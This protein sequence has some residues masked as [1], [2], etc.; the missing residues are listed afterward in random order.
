MYTE[1]SIFIGY[2]CIIPVI[3]ICTNGLI[4]DILLYSHA[5][6]ISCILYLLI[7]QVNTTTTEKNELYG[8]RHLLFNLRL[9]PTTLWFNMGLWDKPDLTFPQACENLVHAV[10]KVMDI[11][12]VSTVLDV[13]FGCGD[14]CIVLAE[15]YTLKVTGITNE[16]SQWRIASDRISSTKLKDQITLIHGSADDLNQHISSTEIYDYIVSIDSAYHYNTRWDF[17]KNALTYLKP[18]GGTIGLYDLCIDSEFL[19]EVSSMQYSFL[20]LIC[21]ASHIPIR[22]LVT[23]E[24]YQKRLVDMGY[25]KIEMISL[26][27]AHVFGGL[28]ESFNDQYNTVMKYGIGVSLSNKIFLKGSSFIFG[29]FGTKPWLVPVIVKGEKA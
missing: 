3:S 8:L 23:V 15:Q 5:L 4:K 6:G 2:V 1:L 24:E 12:P 28:S 20:K 13:G 17:L 27:R 7:N 10:A 25:E 11:K 14:S 9:P 29:L 26:D 16:L 19:K 21:K 22:N 18:K